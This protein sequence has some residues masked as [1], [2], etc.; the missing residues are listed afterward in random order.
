M[1]SAIVAVSVDS[2]RDGPTVVSWAV[3]GPSVAVDVAVGS[4]PEGIDHHHAATVPAGTITHW[5]GVLGPHLP[6]PRPAV[7]GTLRGFAGAGQHSSVRRGYSGKEMR[8]PGSK[9]VST[10]SEPLNPTR[11]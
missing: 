4:S 7:G 1:A 3:A 9:S 2:E 11:R 8:V 6:V 5:L 10:C